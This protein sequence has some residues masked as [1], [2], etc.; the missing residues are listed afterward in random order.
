MEVF[1]LL[2]L[3]LSIYGALHLLAGQAD[4]ELERR[5]EARVAIVKFLLRWERE[6]A[7]QKLPNFS[8]FEQGIIQGLLSALRTPTGNLAFE[9]VLVYSFVTSAILGLTLSVGNALYKDT[10]TVSTLVL[11]AG[12][13]FGIFL[14]FL[15]WPADYFSLSVTEFIFRPNRKSVLSVPFL[16]LIDLLVSLLVPWIPFAL[17]VFVVSWA[18][19]PKLPWQGLLGLLVPI[20]ASTVASIAISIAQAFILLTGIM[21]RGLLSPLSTA[22]FGSRYRERIVSE[23][24]STIV[25]YGMYTYTSAVFLVWSLIRVT[26]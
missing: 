22:G 20:L 10:S 16:I 8:N 25:S 7:N 23:P 17:L 9:K 3:W 6:S 1:N 26:T 15:S 5:P 12:V 14:G 24:I 21:L 18:D 13:L 19:T 4:N 11:P 2:A